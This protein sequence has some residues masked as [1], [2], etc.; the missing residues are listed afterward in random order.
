VD[1][2][3]YTGDSGKAARYVRRMRQDDPSRQ[4]REAAIQL[5]FGTAEARQL[6]HQ[7]LRQADRQALSQII[8]LWMHRSANLPLAD[9]LAGYLTGAN[10]TPDDRRRGAE[11]RLAALAGQG[12]WPEG[13]AAWRQDAGDEPFDAWMVHAYLAGYPAAELAAPMFTRARSRVAR[14]LIPDF[15]RP[16]WDE[17]QQEF[18]ALVHRATLVGDSAEVLK[19]IG[20]MRT[21]RPSTDAADPTA[22]S[23]KAA[24]EARLALLRGDSVQAITLL[25]RSVSRI[26]EPFTWYYPLTS[27]APQRRLLMDLLET[28][29]M[30]AEAR[31]WRDSFRNSWSLGDV[32]FAARLD[33]AGP[34]AGT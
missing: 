6:A 29:G 20:R 23:L 25:Q 12:R 32:L 3:I 17:L 24:L 11:I 31:R 19:L 2:A 22:A 18:Q 16:L 33:S 34:R 4:V 14:G 27:M 15:S 10:R 30:R 7:Q 21:A 5:R 9:T 1:L 13:V 26:N 28:R 8:A